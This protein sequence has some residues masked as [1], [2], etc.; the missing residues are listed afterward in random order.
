M[1]DI[2]T[3]FYK[4]PEMLKNELYNFKIDSWAVGL[5]ILQIWV[6]CR[7]NKLANGKIPGKD[8]WVP[9]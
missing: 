6:K 8:G 2:G 9:S 7:V 3:S 1:T 4:A 5:V